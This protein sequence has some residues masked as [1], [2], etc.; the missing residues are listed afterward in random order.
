MKVPDVKLRRLAVIGICFLLPAVGIAAF[1]GRRIEKANPWLIPL[2]KYAFFAAL[3]LHSALL[4]WQLLRSASLS[5]KLVRR[6]L[7]AHVLAFG[8]VLVVDYFLVEFTIETV[9]LAKYGMLAFC[10]FHWRLEPPSEQLLAGFPQ[11]MRS[12]FFATASVGILEESA[13]YFIPDR[14]CDPRDM[15][16]KIAAA[17]AGTFYAATSAAFSRYTHFTTLATSAG[18]RVPAPAP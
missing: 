10:M 15:A 9:H 12:A 5:S 3:L 18:S 2:I 7:S 16:L 1:F 8:A 14:I 11:A 4:C 6:I 13:Q 17:A